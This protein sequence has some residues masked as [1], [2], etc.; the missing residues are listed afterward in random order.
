MYFKETK[1]DVLET[2]DGVCLPIR[3]WLPKKAPKAV[4]LAIHGAMAHAGDW[5]TP[6][7]F[8]AEKGFATVAFDLR[9][10]GLSPKHNKK[11]KLLLHIDSFEDFIDDTKCVLDYIKKEFPKTP[12]FI[13]GHSFGGLISLNYGLTKAKGEK[14]I[15]GFIV[16]SPWLRNLVEIPPVLRALSKVLA[17][18]YPKLPNPANLDL[19][20]LTHD[21][22]ILKRHV[23][24][25]KG[26]LRGTKATPG[27]LIEAEKA[28]EWTSENLMNWKGFPLF[29]VIAGKDELADPD[30]SEK[31]LAK[32][33]KKFITLINY[34]DNYHENF[35]ETNREEIF[36]KIYKWMM[37][38]LK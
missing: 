37:P 25:E 5:V 13:L 10:H 34:K 11:I 3:I 4:F 20:V 28:Q 16:S 9:G 19:N 24:D 27:F 1:K 14:I 17:V 18:I 32:V 26:G 30:F 23:K 21:K 6:G 22:T 15:K 12:V 35:N 29:A 38:L 33:P 8:F 7:L 2:K 36:N 31:V